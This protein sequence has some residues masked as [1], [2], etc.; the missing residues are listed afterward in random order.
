MG[1]I[2]NSLATPNTE[3]V[4]WIKQTTALPHALPACRL[5]PHPQMTF[6]EILI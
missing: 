5:N 6:P 4:A 2:C 1:V 3:D